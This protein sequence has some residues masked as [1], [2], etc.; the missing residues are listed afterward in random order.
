MTLSR[1]HL[2][3]A[4]LLTSGALASGCTPLVRQVFAP[5][6]PTKALIGTRAFVRRMFEGLDRRRVWDSHLHVLGDGKSG[7]GCA[8]NERFY[9]YPGRLLYDM[10]LGAGGVADTPNA[11]RD[12][13]DLFVKLHELMNPDGRVLALAF[14]YAVRED[15]TVD[16]KIS[17]FYV[18]NSWVKEIA[19][20]HASVLPVG[21][22][23]PY[24]DDAV[25]QLDALVD[26]GFIGI[27]WLPNA[28]RIDT[29]SP[30]CDA[31][32]RRL[33]HHELPLIM[34][35]GHEAAADSEGG[36]AFGNVLRVRRA[37]D[38]GVRV[39]VAHCAGLGDDED[40]DAKEGERR[41]MASYD[42]FRRLM[43]E[44]QYEGRLF[45]DISAMTQ[46]NRAFR[47]LRETI[48]DAELHPRLV[49]GSDFPLPAVRGLVSAYFLERLGYL[50]RN[51]RLHCER[52]ARRNA[53]LY[54]F[55]VK[56]ALTVDDGVT[57]HRF[58]DVVFESSRIFEHLP[59]VRALGITK[60]Q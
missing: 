12:Y 53:L 54:D 6:P 40:I 56:R 30:R 36:Q 32:Y 38:H 23:H 22:I 19:G 13:I 18:P 3:K 28:Q 25:D 16:D 39:V 1:R 24:R 34:H 14:D 44:K 27:K 21:S 11:E 31:F 10:Y 47:P 45:A 33:A 8:V 58:S 5:E 20:K 48:V 59:T 37:L 43:A 15:G 17:E 46:V 55:C 2:L 60:A 51:D 4:S 9:K 57:I 7:S 26:Q 52:L 49:N 50:S 41:V 42:L 35:A 29:T